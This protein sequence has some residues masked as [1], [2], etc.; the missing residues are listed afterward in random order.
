MVGGTWG[1]PP[2]VRFRW[3]GGVP[4]VPPSQV[5]M[6]GGTW[7]TPWPG[8]DGEGYPGSPQPSLDGGG[9]PK[10]PPTITGWGTSPPWLN[11]VSPLPTSIASTCYAVGIMPLAFT[12]EDFL[13]LWKIHTNEFVP[14]LYKVGNVANKGLHRKSKISSA[15]KHCLQ[16]A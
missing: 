2:P 14:K 5:Y 12:Q 11:G 7:G 8:L 6:V 13:V 3:C 10:V 16:W 15:K 1:T 4:G 9:L